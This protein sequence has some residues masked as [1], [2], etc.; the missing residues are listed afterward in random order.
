MHAQPLIRFIVL[1]LCILC[2][3]LI[4]DAVSAGIV[5][6]TGIQGWPAYVTSFVVYAAVLFTA[7]ALLKKYGKIDIFNAGRK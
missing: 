7:L 5:T 1:F 2:A 4:A 6:L 3:I